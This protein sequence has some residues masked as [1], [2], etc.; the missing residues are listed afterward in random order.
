MMYVRHGTWCPDVILWDTCIR[1]CYSNWVKA[2]MMWLVLRGACQK[3]LHRCMQSVGRLQATATANQCCL[4]PCKAS[5]AF[6]DPSHSDQVI[7]QGQANIR[8]LV[9]HA[10]HAC[11][12]DIIILPGGGI[13]PSGLA[14]FLAATGARE[15]HSSAL[16]C[17]SGCPRPVPSW[18]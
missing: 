18:A 4:E 2:C 14:E 12:G 8:T 6:C 10:K 17:A 11:N 13:R 16:R 7:P 1:P 5:S 15:I 9:E 3:P